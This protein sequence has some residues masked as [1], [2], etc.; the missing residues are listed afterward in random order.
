MQLISIIVGALLAI[1]SI[2][3]AARA[4]TARD[5]PFFDSTLPIELVKEFYNLHIGTKGKYATYENIVLEM[6]GAS[7]EN[8]YF[9]VLRDVTDNGIKIRTV[10]DLKKAAAKSDGTDHI[11]GQQIIDR[12]SIADIVSRQGESLIIHDY[13]TNKCHFLIEIKLGFKESK[14]LWMTLE[15]GGEVPSTWKISWKIM[16]HEYKDIWTLL[17]YLQQ[18]LTSAWHYNKNTRNEGT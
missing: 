14:P 2:H 13:D 12:V 6:A 15:N 16:I 1:V 8:C 4:Y 9:L 7:P 5:I 3:Y 10:D 18:L 11:K 17:N